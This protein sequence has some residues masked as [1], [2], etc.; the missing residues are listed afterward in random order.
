MAANS[1][2]TVKKRGPGRPFVKGQ[3]GNP[4]GRPKQTQA[5]KEAVAAK[6]DTQ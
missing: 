2:T 4:S 3:S 6:L 5:Q 1:T